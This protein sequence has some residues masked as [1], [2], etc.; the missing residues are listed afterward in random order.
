MCQ[1]RLLQPTRAATRGGPESVARRLGTSRTVLLLQVTLFLVILSSGPWT[2]HVCRE[3]HV[4]V[5][6]TGGR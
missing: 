4:H 3:D 6:P 5:W 2:K 1:T